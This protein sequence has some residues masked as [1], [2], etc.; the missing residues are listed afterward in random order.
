MSPVALSDEGVPGHHTV[1]VITA[2]TTRLL[3]A[4]LLSAIWVHLLLM[5]KGR[6]LWTTP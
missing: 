6:Q 1:R 2:I 3:C 5:L 4:C